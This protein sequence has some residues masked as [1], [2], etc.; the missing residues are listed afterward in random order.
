MNAFVIAYTQSDFFGKLI[1]LSLIALSMLCWIVLLHKT[2]IIRQVNKWSVAF[3]K[4]I[5]QSKD[6]LLT[7]ELS[8]LPRPQS[9]AIPHPFALIYHSVKQRT[10]EVL[11]KNHYFISQTS[12]KAPVYLS[13]SD[14]ELLE[15][16][17]T[18]TISTQNKA[19]EKN[20]FILST[21]VTLAP[22]MGLLGTVWGILITFSGLQDGG[23]I[24]SNTSI[25]GGLSTALAT[26]VLGLII[27]IPA[28]IAYNYLK[29]SI[30][31]YASDMDDFSTLLLSNIELQYRKVE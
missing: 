22:F 11:N 30:R 17:V 14:L 29:N 2:W 31:N 18:T 21:I 23:A 3:Q 13:P 5:E 27:A 8:H 24:S 7:L 12:T 19:L 16:H 26:T 4:A 1:I 6:P 15:S 28:L 25:L 20:L 10:L 9:N